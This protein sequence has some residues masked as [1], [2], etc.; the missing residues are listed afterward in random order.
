MPGRKRAR[1][2]ALAAKPRPPAAPTPGTRLKSSPRVAATTLAKCARAA[3]SC[4]TCSALAPFCG[5]NTADAPRGPHSGLSTSAA[6]STATSTRRGSSP[7]RSRLCRPASAAPPGASSSPSAARKRTPSAL[8]RPAPASLVALPPRPRMIFRAPASSAA[9]ISSPVPRLL[10]RVASRRSRGT[11]CKPLAEAISITAVASSSQP[12]CARVGSPSGPSTRHSR[13]SPAVAASTAST[14]PSPPSASGRSNTSA[15]G[16]TRRQPRAIA[17]ATSGADRL[18][19]N[20]SGAI[21]IFISHLAGP[22]V[23]GPA[24][25]R[26]AQG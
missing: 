25:I 13:R 3:S 15:C 7:P 21:T 11:R 23:P 17:S 1:R 4:A 24:S 14:V 10:L 20:E 22:G 8:S 16:K 12:Q 6:T 18:S 19:L 9:R 2:N 26:A 5:P